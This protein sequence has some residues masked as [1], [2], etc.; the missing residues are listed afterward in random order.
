MQKQL[1]YEINPFIANSR[2]IKPLIVSSYMVV[3][4]QVPD[5]KCK[6]RN[7]VKLND[8]KLW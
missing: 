2:L 8:L 5:V 3:P 6:K 7:E 1:K 4:T